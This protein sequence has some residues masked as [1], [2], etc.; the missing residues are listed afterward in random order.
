MDILSKQRA[1]I[2][3][4]VGLGKDFSE[5]CALLQ[6]AYGEE[7]FAKQTIQHWPKSFCDGCQVTS[8]LPCVGRPRSLNTEVNVKHI[9]NR[10]RYFEKRPA[11]VFE[12]DA[13]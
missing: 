9:S 13:E 10:G 1:T 4:C 5:T 8:G 7:C 3:F 6:E 11:M 2:G 12:D